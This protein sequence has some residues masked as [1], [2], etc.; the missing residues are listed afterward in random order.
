MDEG[1]FRVNPLLKETNR[2]L[3]AENGGNPDE[4]DKPDGAT[5]EART[6]PYLAFRGSPYFISGMFVAR[7]RN[8][9]L[10]ELCNQK[11]A[12]RSQRI[13]DPTTDM[14]Y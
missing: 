5:G 9:A 7:P 12:G 13:Y 4:Y 2:R 10:G 6:P 14:G 11:A 8:D 3:E 1:Y